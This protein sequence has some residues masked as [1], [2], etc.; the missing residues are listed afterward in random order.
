MCVV[1]V[2]A[3]CWPP[4]IR[5]TGADGHG[6]RVKRTGVRQPRGGVWGSCKGEFGCS[7]SRRIATSD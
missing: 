6:R 1:V 7:P 2:A 4:N 5:T 3:A